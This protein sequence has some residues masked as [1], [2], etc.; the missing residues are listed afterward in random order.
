MYSTVEDFVSAQPADRQNVLAAVHSIIIQEDKTV[1]PAIETMMGKEMIIYKNRGF[2]KYGLGSMKA[3]MSL[4][5][6]PIYGSSSL[7]TKYK[8][9][10]SKANFQ[11]GC[12]NFGSVEEMP[13]DIL[14]QLISDCSAIDLVKIREDYL[15]EK[16]KNKAKK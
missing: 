11:K 9:R 8:S 12:I 2:M 3:Y 14:R 15:R 13:L 7:Y 6:L 5:V 4:H 1:L 16:K 10:L